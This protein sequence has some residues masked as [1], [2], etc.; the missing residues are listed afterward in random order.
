MMG[1]P[2]TR[3][4]ALSIPAFCLLIGLV[5]C[6]ND[7][8][9]EETPTWQ[10][11]AQGQTS[12]LLGVWGSSST[13]VWAVGGRASATEGPVILHYDGAA[14]ARVESGQTNLDLWWVTGAGDGAVL[15]S[16]SGG[17]ILRYHEG[18]F[19]RLNTPGMTGTIF[20]M[21]AAGPNDIWAVGDAGAA[22]GVVWHSTNGEDFEAVALPDPAPKRV[23]KVNG[24]ASDDVW[25][26]CASGVTLRWNGSELTAEQAPTTNS[27]FSIVATPEV[28]VTVG[29]TSGVG[30][31]LVHDGG[32]WEQ[33]ALTVPV[34]WRGAAAQGSDVVVVGENGLVARRAGSGWDVIDQQLTTRNFHAAWLDEELGLW[35]VGGVFDTRLSDG[36]LLYYGV[37]TIAEV[38]Q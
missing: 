12:A 35:A 10:G 28:A 2:S 30:D 36:L 21:W 34:A 38:A 37:Q 7:P 29:G 27:L 6:G 14:W 26:S 31:L 24:R 20:G 23:F 33:A 15:F 13:D 19:R 18:A 5:G 16:G 4:A 8:G 9:P 3:A 17:T 1:I 32:S 25:M 11:I 22:G